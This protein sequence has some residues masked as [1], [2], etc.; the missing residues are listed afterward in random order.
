MTALPA[1]ADLASGTT[2]EAAFQQAITDLVNFV[3]EL[4]GG[5]AQESLTISSGAITP[6]VAAVKVDT[7]GFASTDNLTTIQPSSIGEK[8]LLLQIAS[9]SRTVVVKHLAGGSGQIELLTGA[10]VTLDHAGKRMLLRYDD[11][12]ARWIEVMR[13]WGLYMP[14][15]GDATTARTALGLGTVATK[16]TGT[17]G[18]AVPLLNVANIWDARQVVRKDDQT[19][20]TSAAFEAQSNEGNV[21]IAWRAVGSS[22]AYIEHVRGTPGLHVKASSGVYV[23]IRAS[24]FLT[25]TGEEIGGGDVELWQ[26]V[27]VGAPVSSI[28]VLGLEAGYDY[29]FALSHIRPVNDDQQLFMQTAAS[30]VSW[31]GTH[32]RVMCIMEESNTIGVGTIDEFFESGTAFG[33]SGTGG[34]DQHNEIDCVGDYDIVML[35]PFNATYPTRVFGRGFYGGSSTAGKKFIWFTG[36]RDGR[37]SSVRFIYASGNISAGELRVYRRAR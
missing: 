16:N 37:V 9:T 10:D 21:I 3:K 7:E 26:S 12:S 35:D 11:A 17:S 28:E 31:G 15:S 2:T 5:A 4:P 6:T 14:V 33:L 27:T 36:S 22:A 13:N 19:E 23:P 25:P 24:Q 1:V 8:F 34:H 32:I 30:G 20:F 18:D 29:I